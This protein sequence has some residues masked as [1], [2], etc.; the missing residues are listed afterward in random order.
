[1]AW[2]A[3]EQHQRAK[4]VV[5]E[6]PS[7]GK[8]VHG[9]VY[10]E[11]ELCHAGWTRSGEEGLSGSVYLS[12][13]QASIIGVGDTVD[14]LSGSGNAASLLNTGGTVDNVT[15]SDGTVS[16]AAQATPRASPG[17]T[18]RLCSTSQPSDWTTSTATIR[19]TPCPLA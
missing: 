17:R 3:P 8:P 12:A 13:A 15:G 10:S 11:I 1:M 4:M 5:V 9:Q 19:R 14:F 6:T 16:W 2:T 7:E 18:T